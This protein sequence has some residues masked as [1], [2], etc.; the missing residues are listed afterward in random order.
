MNVFEWAT[1]QAARTGTSVEALLRER[2][3][4]WYHRRTTF[5]AFA[6]CHFHYSTLNIG[7]LGTP[8]YGRFC[9]VDDRRFAEA[10][11]VWIADD[12][13]RCAGFW[14][15]DDSL[16]EAGLAALV[17]PQDLAAE[18][19]I[20]KL[21]MDAASATLDLAAR[22]CREDGYVEGLTL[23]PI[24]AGRVQEIRSESDDDLQDRALDAAVYGAGLGEDLDLGL[25]LRIRTSAAALGIEWTQVTP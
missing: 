24:Q 22:V 9:V 14:A 15:P 7:G 6:D 8:R 21:S 17:A 1:E 10:D 5:E 19:T 3:K 2:L 11:P 18:L 20:I 25:H 23:T 13:L 4:E 12:S 16:H